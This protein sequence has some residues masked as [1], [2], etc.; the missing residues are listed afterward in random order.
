MILNWYADGLPHTPLSSPATIASVAQLRFPLVRKERQSSIPSGSGWPEEVTDS[1]E[2]KVFNI[3]V[4]RGMYSSSL[5]SLIVFGSKTSS[6]I[7]RTCRA[8]PLAIKRAFI[9]NN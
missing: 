6:C 7:A 8:N 5:I 1:R 3:Y 4:I 2:L 9:I